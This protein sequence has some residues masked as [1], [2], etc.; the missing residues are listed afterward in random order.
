MN[1]VKKFSYSKP[2]LFKFKGQEAYAGNCLAGPGN[3]DGVDGAPCNT[4]GNGAF[5]AC[6]IGNAPNDGDICAVGGGTVSG[7][8]CFNGTTGD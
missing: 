3:L 4:Y 1:E 8:V 2:S 7:A 5:L 6:G